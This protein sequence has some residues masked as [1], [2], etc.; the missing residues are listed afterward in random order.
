MSNGAA[1]IAGSVVLVP[2]QGGVAGT[3]YAITVIAITSNAAKRPGFTGLLQ[4][5]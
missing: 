1:S 4:V 2:V 3:D 5:R